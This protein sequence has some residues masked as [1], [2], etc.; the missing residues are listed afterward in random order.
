[1]RRRRSAGELVVA[2]VDHAHRR[3]ARQARARPELTGSDQILELIGELN[4]DGCAAVLVQ[5]DPTANRV[6]CAS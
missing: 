5:S 4:L 2:Q 1:M 3:A 6:D